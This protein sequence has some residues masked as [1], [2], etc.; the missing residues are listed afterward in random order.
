MSLYTELKVDLKWAD[1]STW[2]MTLPT[3]EYLKRWQ[4][5]DIYDSIL[6]PPGGCGAAGVPMGIVIIRN[7]SS[8]EDALLSGIIVQVDRDYEGFSDTVTL[9]GESDTSLLR[10]R[11]IE[12]DPQGMIPNVENWWSP[13]G[14]VADDSTS[15][16]CESV[17]SYYVNYNMG[18][19][20]TTDRR[21]SYLDCAYDSMRGVTVQY[22]GRFQ[23][24]FD[25]C[26]EIL[27]S[28]APTGG[29][30]SSTTMPNQSFEIKQT[31]ETGTTR[32]LYQ[33]LEP[34]DKTNQAI[35]GTEL[36]T[37]PKFQYSEALPIA[38]Y[39]LVGGPDY[40]AQGGGQTT[41]TGKRM[42]TS[43]LNLTSAQLYGRREKQVNYGGN[44]SG[45]SGTDAQAE[46]I[47][48][49]MQSQ[50]LIEAANDSYATSI[51]IALRPNEGP[52]FLQNWDIGNIVTVNLGAAKGVAK[53]G[54]LVF[55]ELIREVE[56]DIN[57]SGD[58]E[59]VTPTICD[60]MKF[61]RSAGYAAVRAAASI[62]MLQNMGGK[63]L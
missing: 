15:G 63:L 19:H 29:G 26:L 3:A 51:T 34:V 23:Y 1:M 21:L 2:T 8:I 12:P 52:L 56:L 27:K 49:D 59:T 16:P 31:S 41:D 58:G 7:N 5:E 20:S 17:L 24:L 32:A 44:V 61:S 48:S 53:K 36:G 42:F 25:A 47:M 22:Q 62:R 37:I 9:T 35:F 30:T 18:P 54:N 28:Q 57:P 14:T 50:A 6:A 33:W 4:I 40:Y 45:T 11:Y 10:T 60:A 55:N 43:L 46:A 13:D 38:N 39:I